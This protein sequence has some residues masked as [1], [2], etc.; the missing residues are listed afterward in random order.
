MCLYLGQYFLLDMPSRWCCTLLVT[1]AWLLWL[2]LLAAGLLLS[3]NTAYSCLPVHCTVSEPFTE[4]WSEPFIQIF[5]EFAKI[6]DQ[7]LKISA[8]NW[9]IG[10]IDSR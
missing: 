8:L 9:C 10:E 2:Y 1:S 6:F 3:I 4:V 7:I 5:K